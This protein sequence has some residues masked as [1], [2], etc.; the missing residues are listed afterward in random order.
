MDSNPSTTMGPLHLPAILTLPTPAIPLRGVHLNPIQYTISSKLSSRIIKLQAIVSYLFSFPGFTGRVPWLNLTLEG[1]SYPGPGYAH[2]PASGGYVGGQYPP[3][4]SSPTSAFTTTSHAYSTYPGGVGY[5]QSS[6]MS[7]AQYSSA[8]APADHAHQRQDS[9]STVLSSSGHSPTASS[10]H[11]ESA[12]RF[13]CP[14]CEKSFTRNFDRK[15]HME[16]HVPNNSGH[17]RCRWCLKDYSRPDSLKR[18]LDN[19]CERRPS[20]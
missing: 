14:H 4:G 10:A 5:P 18:H 19:G 7:Y 15:R 16:I 11:R 3:T 8:R 2:P 13:Q 6:S 12:E 20:S 9:S 1:Q 17:N